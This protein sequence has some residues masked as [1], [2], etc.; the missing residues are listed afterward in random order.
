MNDSKE[1][2]KRQAEDEQ[3]SSQTISGNVIDISD[4]EEE[5]EC[6]E[7]SFRENNAS[8]DSFK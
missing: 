1:K 6:T 8:Q 7:F 5:D 3:N 2:K 4:G